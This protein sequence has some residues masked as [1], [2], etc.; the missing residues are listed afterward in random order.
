MS[1]APKPIECHVKRYTCADK[2]RVVLT[3]EDGKHWCH[4]VQP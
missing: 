1:W 3:S 2:S 4:K